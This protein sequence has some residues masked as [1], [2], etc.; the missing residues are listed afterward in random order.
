MRWY[1]AINT[2]PA[3]VA[4]Y[5]YTTL[6]DL[7]HR[8]TD[9]VSSIIDRASCLPLLFLRTSTGL[10]VLISVDLRRDARS[11]SLQAI[12]RARNNDKYVLVRGCAVLQWVNIFCNGAA[13]SISC[14]NYCTTSHGITNTSTAPVLLQPRAHLDPY[15]IHPKVSC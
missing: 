7:A 6:V 13:R 12:Y 15:F 10:A 11:Q 2:P 5:T 4:S 9:Y 1:V 14:S 8:L 3:A